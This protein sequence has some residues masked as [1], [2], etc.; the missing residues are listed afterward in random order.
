MQPDIIHLV[1]KTHL[2]IG[3]T[4]HA[5]AVRRQYHERFI[6]QAL[7]TAE[8]FW[9]E[10]PEDPA[11]VWTTGAWLIH[12]HLHQA[13]PAQAARLENAIGKGLIRW[14][15]LPFTTHSELMSPALFRAGLSY[16]Q[17]LDARFGVTTRAAKMTDVPGHTLG[18][19]PL[20]AA[21]GVRFLHLGVNTACPVPDLPDLF[22]WRAPDGSEI[23]VMYQN[24]YGDT[25]LPEGMTEALS[26]AHTADNIG[27]QSVAQTG[28]V[29]RAL[30]RAHPQA[31]I[32]AATLEE[33]G[34]LLWARREAL[35]VVEC[36]IGDSWIHGAASDPQKLA[37][38][39]ALQR[40]HDRFEAEG[41]T[42]PRRAFGRGLC[43]VAEHTWGVD[44]KTYLRDEAAW[45]RLAFEQARVHDPRF[46]IT[47]LSWDEQRA[48]LDDALSHLED[49]DRAAAAAAEAELAVPEVL[50][51]P[52]GD[53]MTVASWSVEADDDSGGI[54]RLV[55]PGGVTLEGDGGPVLSFLHH[56]YDAADMARHL[57]SYLTDRPEWA[58]L[59][60]DKPGLARAATARSASFR[61][62]GI[63]VTRDGETLEIAAAFPA[64]AHAAL[65][66]PRRSRWRIAPGPE[67]G[68]RIALILDDK[69]A[70][71]MPEAGFIRIAPRE[72]R[73]WRL[74]KT[75]LWLD[76]AVCA[77]RGGGALQGIFG[78]RARLARGGLH[79]VPLDT[80]L[81]APAGQ[82]LMVFTARPPSWDGGLQ[83]L[84]YTNKWGTNFPMWWSGG[85]VSRIDLRLED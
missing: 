37:R 42:E 16:A 22:R 74:E 71:R 73:D 9:R 52:A 1:F 2:D 38:F 6:P 67:G 45:D 69:P 50:R 30:R 11:F 60:H 43:M 7:T 19:V 72:A 78:A 31:R 57:D 80:A 25:H 10:N 3:F 35:P 5:Q 27:P 26:F 82:D 53:A 47:E 54:A 15:A 46:A 28:E 13:D 8:H 18:I 51:S 20:L 23:V 81:A 14:H 55:S 75:G 33:Y 34:A 40:L 61:P 63:A 36:E 56:S 85:L 24:S 64:E 62:G 17:E 79:L 70:N 12:D 44:I 76:P 39:R 65:G 48:Y 21:A 77:P 29:Y 49:E 66:A 59:D 68:L 32:R 84:T 83:L 4:D 58:V 41:L